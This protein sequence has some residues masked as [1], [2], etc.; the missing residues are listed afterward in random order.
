MEDDQIIDVVKAMTR[1]FHERGQ[2]GRSQGTSSTLATREAA[3]VGVFIAIEYK[4]YACPGN[5]TLAPI[6]VQA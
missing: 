5:T 2:V 6:R 4:E 3:S 1:N